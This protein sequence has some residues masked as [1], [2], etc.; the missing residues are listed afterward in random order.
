MTITQLFENSVNKFANNTLVLEKGRA[1]T[2]Q[3]ITYKQI[4]DRVYSFSMGLMKLGIKKGDRLA[5]LSEGRSEWLISELGMLYLGAISVPLSVKINEPKDLGFRIDHSGCKFVVISERQ[6]H[7]VRQ[8]KNKLPHIEKIIVIT[9]ND[10][11]ELQ[12]NEISYANV[13]KIGKS[14]SLM[15]EFQKTWKSIQGDDLANISYTSGTTADPKGIMLSHRNYTANVEQ[16]KT[17]IEVPEYYSSLLILPWDHSFGH[18]VGLYTLIDNGASLSVVELGNTLMETL[19]NIPKNINETQPTFLLSVPALAKNFKKNIESGI[20]AKGPK[21]EKLFNKALKVAYEYNGIGW[22][23]GKGSQLLSRPLLWLYDK[24]LFSKVRAGFGGKL[25]FFIGG[26]ALLDIELQKFFYAIGIPMYQGYGLSESAPII[27]SNAPRK[28]K[29]GSS[30][31]IVKNLELK[32][33]D[34]KGNELP[35]GQKGEIVVKGENIMKGYW[36]NESATKEALRDGWL[37]T[38]DMGYT[39]VDGFL[40]VLGRFKSLLI[41]NDGEKYSPEGIEEALVEQSQLIDQVML[42]NNQNNYTIALIHPNKN[43][44]AKM[45]ADKGQNINTEEGAK[46]AISTIQAEVDKYLSD[47]IYENMFPHRWIPA[48]FG[49]LEE[50]FTEENRLLNSTMKMVRGKVE[51]KHKDQIENLQTAEGKNIFNQRNLSAFVD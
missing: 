11:F 41:G 26:G 37:Y 10:D 34:E 48:T 49:I 27:S 28:H 25:E 1:S 35:T 44:L 23:K 45:V 7:K 15:E 42:Y 36:K 12:E 20:K 17:L 29:L 24:I 8:L 50:G 40:Y 21:V 18:T 47:G 51:E 6:L 46:L 13:V 16:A 9:D 19:R 38:G 32:I 31:F 22:D 4:K 2:Y 5:L 39:D 14:E 43:L 30:G 3:P 33:C